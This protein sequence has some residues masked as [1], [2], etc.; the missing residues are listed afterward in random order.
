[1]ENVPAPLDREGLGVAVLLLTGRIP[2]E[3][4]TEKESSRLVFNS[5]AEIPP[6]HTEKVDDI[7]KTRSYGPQI[8]V[9]TMQ[10]LILFLLSITTSTSLSTAEQTLTTTSPSNRRIAQQISKAMIT[11]IQFYD[12]S[13]LEIIHYD[14]FSAFLERDAPYLLDPLVPLFQKFLY[15]QHKWGALPTREDWVGGLH[16]DSPSEL[17]NLST[18][19]QISMFL[20]K[21]RRLG[22][23]VSLYAGSKDGFSMGMFESKVLKYPGISTRNTLIKR[24]V[25][26]IDTRDDGGGYYSFTW[27][28]SRRQRSHFWSIRFNTLEIIYKGYPSPFVLNNRKFWR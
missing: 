6:K 23:L 5:L 26:I 9:I 19:A 1:L 8:S 16:V 22:T 13:P 24:T 15:D 18:L 25:D 20:P 28:T 2:R 4:L 14:A 27:I 17:M 11:A 12:K 7:S 10:E 21:E 3:V